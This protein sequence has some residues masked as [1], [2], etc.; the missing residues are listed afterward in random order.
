MTL[1]SGSVSGGTFLSVLKKLFLFFLLAGLT[2]RCLADGVPRLEAK[3]LSLAPTIDGV[4]SPG[5]WEMA[6]KVE[7]LRDRVTGQFP[8]SEDLT[9]IYMGYNK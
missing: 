1:N 6:S 4:L 9:E 7:A 3:K 2:G 5:E 8:S